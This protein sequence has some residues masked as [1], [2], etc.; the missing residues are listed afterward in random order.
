MFW[1]HFMFFH[2]RVQG[3]TGKKEFTQQEFCFHADTEFF[4][5]DIQNYLQRKYKILGMEK[6]QCWMKR[7]A[8]TFRPF[9]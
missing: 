5:C 2:V 1:P 7:S 3:G 8:Y 6:Y 4:Y 9:L